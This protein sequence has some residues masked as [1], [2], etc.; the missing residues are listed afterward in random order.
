M[1]AE[2]AA[3][4][5]SKAAKRKITAEQIRQDIADGAPT[6]GDGTIHLVN[7]TAWLSGQAE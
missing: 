3:E 5:L 1:T 4:L 2:Q 6:N 7:Y